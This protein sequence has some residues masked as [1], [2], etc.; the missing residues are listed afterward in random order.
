MVRWEEVYIYD[1]LDGIF[2]LLVVLFVF[3]IYGFLSFYIIVEISES[4]IIIVVL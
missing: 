1:I 3:F 4:L 2:N